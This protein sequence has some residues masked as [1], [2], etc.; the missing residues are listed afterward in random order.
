VKKEAET[1]SQL[2]SDHYGKAL[3]KKGMVPPPESS[4]LGFD[5]KTKVA[6]IVAEGIPDGRRFTRRSEGP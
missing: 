2:V 3:A 1:Y 6:G 4:Y 5:E